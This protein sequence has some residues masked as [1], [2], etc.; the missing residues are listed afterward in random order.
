M[1]TGSTYG[2]KISA[3]SGDTMSSALDLFASEDTCQ[4]VLSSNKAIVKPTRDNTSTD[5][6]FCLPS[7][8]THY[9]DLSKSFFALLLKFT[10]ADKTSIGDAS[11]IK[12]V[13]GDN[14]PHA[15][16]Q[17]V[18]VEINGVVVESAPNYPLMSLI[19]NLIDVG[20][21]EKKGRKSGEGWFEDK[22]M[23]MNTADGDTDSQ[24]KRQALVVDN[25]QMNLAFQL[26]LQTLLQARYIP[27]GVQVTI[28]LRRAPVETYVMSESTT[29]AG[30]CAVEISEFEWHVPRLQVNPSIQTAHNSLLVGGQ[31]IKIP[32]M[33]R[34]DQTHNIPAGVSK[35]TVTH[36]TNGIIPE[37]LRI[38]FVDHSAR[39]GDFE[40][41]ACRFHHF[42][43][44]E[45]EVRVDG[46]SEGRRI[47]VDFDKHHYADAYRRMK[48]VS[49]RV[50]E[51]PRDRDFDNGIRY[52]QFA[53]GR[54]VFCFDLT[55]DSCGDG[56]HLLSNGSISLHFTFHKGL[57]NNVCCYV[58]ELVPEEISINYENQVRMVT[59]V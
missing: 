17:T 52:D 5:I 38:A 58:Y 6:E 10:K 30:G 56:P 54:V 25:R 1:A 28:K 37:Q 41:N 31:S 4:S 40:K 46:L 24:K 44:K 9:T 27:P 20:I 42:D 15:L 18:S 53:N 55:P 12:I 13:P 43:V 49:G 8:E 59:G 32:I 3:T 34:S 47:E 33:R 7:S 14:L 11:A 36:K 26:N 19:E 23:C 50:G 29:P 35:A 21:Q 16:F 45:I 48:D 2:N 39:G 57:A 22:T 51:T